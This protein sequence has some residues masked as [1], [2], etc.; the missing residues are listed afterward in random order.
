MLRQIREQVLEMKFHFDDLWMDKLPEVFSLL[1]FQCLEDYL[2]HNKWWVSV[3]WMEKKVYEIPSRH[4]GM[5]VEC[6]G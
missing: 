2:T 6:L 3:C 1:Y 4:L 5:W